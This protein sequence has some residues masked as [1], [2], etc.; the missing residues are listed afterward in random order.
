MLATNCPMWSGIFHYREG[1]FSH[2]VG[3][4]E[5]SPVLVGSALYTADGFTSLSST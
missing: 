4:Q 1:V 3:V 2:P 5:I